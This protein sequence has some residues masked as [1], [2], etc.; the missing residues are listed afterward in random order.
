VQRG[1]CVGQA[2]HALC[3]DG[4]RRYLAELLVKARLVGSVREAFAR[5]LH[6]LGNRS[7]GPFVALSLAFFG[8]LAYVLVTSPYRILPTPKIAEYPDWAI[9][10]MCAIVT[11][12]GAWT[13]WRVISLFRG[14]SLLETGPP[15]G[16]EAQS[17][18][19]GYGGPDIDRRE[20]RA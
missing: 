15:V 18:S 11:A 9:S 16:S 4:R 5:Y 10:A 2:G 6:S 12:A 17:A 14:Q 7:A 13:A 19:P 3:T 1:K 8:S 20:A